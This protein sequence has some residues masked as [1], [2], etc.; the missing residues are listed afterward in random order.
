MASLIPN[1]TCDC[2]IRRPDT[3][4]TR[5]FATRRAGWRRLAAV[6]AGARV[7]RAAARER[8]TGPPGRSPLRTEQ[9]RASPAGGRGL[10]ADH[11]HRR[12]AARASPPCVCELS[13]CGNINP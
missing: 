11:V 9:L 8:H 6:R 12:H 1:S 13:F 7:R 5:G 2:R 3:S 10:A 4:N